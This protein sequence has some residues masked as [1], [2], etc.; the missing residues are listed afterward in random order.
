MNDAICDFCGIELVTP[1]W[2]W[3]CPDFVLHL[4]FTSHG[5]KI[6]YNGNWHACVACN[7]LI[8]QIEKVRDPDKIS[9]Q[10]DELAERGVQG[11]LLH[12]K[13]SEDDPY[14]ETVRAVIRETQSAFLQHFTG[15][16]VLHR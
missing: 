7:D 13:Q 1:F 9:P 4:I 5:D 3:E 6:D 10:E 15:R 16:K 8:M 11:A 12:M 14:T 2:E